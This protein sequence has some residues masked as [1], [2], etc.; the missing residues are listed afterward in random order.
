M[1]RIRNVGLRSEISI[2]KISKQ[3][4]VLQLV[5]LLSIS[6]QENVVNVLNGIIDI[7]AAVLGRRL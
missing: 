3:E 2:R 6:M 1:N 4:F 7:T 5:L